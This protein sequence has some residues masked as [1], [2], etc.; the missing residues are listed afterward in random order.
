MRNELPNKYRVG[1]PP[2]R[3]SRHIVGAA[4]TGGLGCLF[5]VLAMGLDA[6]AEELAPPPEPPAAGVPDR[7]LDL[8]PPPLV[9]LR[10]IS[11]PLGAELLHHGTVLGKTP[12]ELE[13]PESSVAE[14][15]T[16]RLAGYVEQTFEIVPDLPGTTYVVLTRERRRPSRVALLEANAPAPCLPCA[17]MPAMAPHV[18]AV[19]GEP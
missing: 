19:R 17:A 11:K 3:R 5:A 18:A 9:S 13:L 8:A 4:V 6:P 16:V 15:I 12:F 7:P 10:V 2:R 1:S 14:R